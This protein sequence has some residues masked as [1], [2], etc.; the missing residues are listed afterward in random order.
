LKC[1]KG[2]KVRRFPGR[3]RKISLCIK[4]SYQERRKRQGKSCTGK[5]KSFPGV[6]KSCGK[7]S[8]ISLDVFDE[9][10]DDLL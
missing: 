2:E 3:R 5:R 1:A 9:V 7:L 4:K 6:F 10:E 8:G